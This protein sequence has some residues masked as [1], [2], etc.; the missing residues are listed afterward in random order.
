M[1]DALCVFNG[2]GG[3]IENRNT[4]KPGTRKGKGNYSATR[5]GERNIDDTIVQPLFLS[6]ILDLTNHEDLQ[7]TQ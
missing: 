2:N 3:N 5:V 4:V 7:P 1:L 6:T